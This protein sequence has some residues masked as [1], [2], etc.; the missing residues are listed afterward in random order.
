MLGQVLALTLLLL[1]K[2]HQG[3]GSADHVV[4]ISGQP[5]WLRPRSL[6]TNIFSVKWKIQP[7]SSSSNCFTWSWSNY[8]GQIEERR[9]LGQN[10][11]CFNK[12]FNFTSKDF[13]LLIEAAQPQDSGLYILEVTS[14]SG[15]F[16]K[17]KFN[18]S[19]FDRVEKPHLVEKWK[20]LDGGICQVTLSCLVARGGDVSYAWYKGSNLIQI[21][22]NITELVEN[23]DVNA[24]HVYTCN[25]SNPV[26]WA[27]HSL[28]LTQG[29]QSDHQDF[30]FLIIL[31]S[32]VIL[33]VALFLSTLT[34]ICVWRRKRKQSRTS[35]KVLTI[36]EDVNNLRTRSN[37]PLSSGHGEEEENKGAE[38]TK[39]AE[40]DLGAELYL[41]GKDAALEQKPP[42]EGNTI[43]STIQA[44]ASA[45][46][47]QDNANTL[48]SLV[49]ASWK[50]G[51]KK[52]KQSPSFDKTIYEEVG[53][54]PSKAE[55]P[56]R[57][58][59][60]ELENFCVYS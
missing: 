55:N 19:I 47:S 15:N 41:L 16:W 13:T 44:Q 27:N 12:S 59:R 60:R 2:G 49:Q 32:I 22:G 8:S 52:T 56:A 14:H 45:S 34:Y 57:L 35:P 10:P 33:L 9:T 48:Y 23:I 51:S 54:R 36:Y 11:N 20:V 50:T 24:S 42:G 28:Q 29:C 43:Y 31:V 37:Q 58:S 4:A 30:T 17:H 46:T 18:V 53:K 40:G 21:P 26:S 38:K 25:V 1:I 6:Q 7:Y 5:V 39:E 3:Q